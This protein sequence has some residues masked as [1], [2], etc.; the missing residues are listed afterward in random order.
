MGRVSETV[1]D[2][3]KG[4]LVGS[5]TRRINVFYDRIGIKRVV[6]EKEVME[7]IDRFV[8]SDIPKPQSKDKKDAEKPKRQDAAPDKK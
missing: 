1:Y 2:Q 8:S 7:M 5:I 6:T 4:I 3:E